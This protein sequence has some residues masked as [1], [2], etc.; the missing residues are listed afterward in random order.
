MAGPQ[1]GGHQPTAGGPQSETNCLSQDQGFLTPRGQRN[2]PSHQRRSQR[3]GRR[4]GNPKGT[5][6]SPFIP[7]RPEAGCPAVLPGQLETLRRRDP[8]VRP[9]L[10]LGGKALNPDPLTPEPILITPGWWH[11]HKNRPCPSRGWGDCTPERGYGVSTYALAQNNATQTPW[12][13]LENLKRP[14]WLCHLSVGLSVAF[15]SNC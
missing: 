7:L 11:C 4:E 9:R 12:C 8:A 13:L 14:P 5:L 2:S 10:Y 3:S 15:P 6:L 1:R